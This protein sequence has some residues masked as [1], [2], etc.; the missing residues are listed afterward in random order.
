MVFQNYALFPHMSVAE[1]VAYGLTVRR[2]TR[3]E[4]TKRVAEALHMTRLEGFG[5]RAIRE[6]SGGQQQR[7]A[8][9]RAFVFS[10]A[11]LLFDEPLSNLD[12]KLRAEMRLEIKELQ[13]TLGITSVYVTHDLEEALAISDRIVVMR[14]GMIE[15]TG[16]PTEIYDRPRNR[17]VADFVG[18]A[19]LIEGRLRP[20]LAAEG[21]VAIETASGAIVRGVA[22]DRRPGARPCF[23]VR[24]VHVRLSRQRPPAQVNVWPAIV[25]RRVFQGDFTQYHADW[26]GRTLV[27]RGLAAEG[28]EEGSTAYVAVEPRHCVLLEE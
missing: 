10:P 2:L 1:N 23:S 27:V 28:I 13:R 16:T 4:I 14:D 11:V 8:L 12:A 5:E 24:T 26:E 22:H 17:F 15:Q 3:E 9:A 20:D 19:N 21:L 6:L 18:S 25:R 7:V